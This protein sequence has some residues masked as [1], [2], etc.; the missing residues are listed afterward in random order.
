MESH[1]SNTERHPR[2]AG[3]VASALRPEG[4]RF[5]LIRARVE[6]FVPRGTV[7]SIRTAIAHV[8]RHAPW[9][10]EEDV[11]RDL[12]RTG[13]SRADVDRQLARAR[14]LREW[15]PE[16]VLEHVTAIGHCTTEGQR[17]VRRTDRTGTRPFERMYVLRCERCGHEHE[18][19]GGDIHR[20]RCS[21]CDVAIE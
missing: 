3:F 20:C 2:D 18:C 17:V 13:V 6:Q 14:A 15:A 8:L 9:M 11:R 4:E 1:N 21:I 19:G 16:Y 12:E 10:T 5:C 7:T